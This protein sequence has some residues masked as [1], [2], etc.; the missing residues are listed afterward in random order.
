MFS[1]RLD[2]SF[3][4]V[5]NYN[6]VPIGFR[7]PAAM[8]CNYAKLRTI[9]LPFDWA[10]P[11]NPAKTKKVLETNFVDFLPSDISNNI[12][13]DKNNNPELKNKYGFIL[14]HFN[15]NID[16]GV[17]EYKRRINRLKDILKED[18]KI[19]FVFINQDYLNNPVFRNEKANEDKYIEML[20]LSKTIKKLYDKM[21]F[22][23]LYFDF[24][25]HKKIENSN[26]VQI[27][28]STDKYF[29]NEEESTFNEFRIYCGEILKE[30]F[31]P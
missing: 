27:T 23:I 22:D 15:K 6:V 4:L 11:L 31:T 3:N 9:S 7:C 24:V 18:K 28:I 17:N 19:Y 12:M 14:C 29:L 8:A 20:D 2:S 10:S 1:H 25:K 16:E 30:L 21:D 26:I 5:K 13:Y